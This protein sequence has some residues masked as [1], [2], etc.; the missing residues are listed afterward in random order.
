M[1]QDDTYLKVVLTFIAFMQLVIC[2]RLVSAPAQ[3]QDAQR[4]LVVNEYLP[5]VGR[6][7]EPVNVRITSPVR[8]E[9]GNDGNP[10][11]VR[12]TN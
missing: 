2:V 1:R 8:L 9:G 12:V 5:V 3:A 4:V 10:V 6:S 7:A 11:Y